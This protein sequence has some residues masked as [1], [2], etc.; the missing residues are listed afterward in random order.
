MNDTIFVTGASGHLGRLVL[1]HLLA[2]GVTPARLIAGTRSPEKLAD[3]AAAGITVRKADFEDRQG[4]TDAFDGV[5]TVLVISTDALEEAGARLKQHRTAIAAAAAGV[6][7]LAYTSQFNPA[8]SLLSFANDHLETERAIQ[9]SGLPHVIFR[10]GWYHENLL[11]SLPAALKRGQWHSAAQGGRTSYAARED[12]AEA[13]AAVL[14]GSGTDSR[15]YTLTGS[16]ALNREEI[17]ERARRATGQPLTVVNVTD[18]QFAEGLKA[19]GVPGAFIPVLV[20][21][22]AETRAGNLSIVTDHLASL[23]ARPPKRLADH[24]DAAK[25]SYLA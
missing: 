22:E 19:A 9:A 13:I 1:Q 4:L 12:I 25:A 8:S 11:M 14:A 3:L 15:I 5:G 10:N 20:S 16:E 17:A 7:R 2:R 23:L 18:E 6:G 21:I 24:L